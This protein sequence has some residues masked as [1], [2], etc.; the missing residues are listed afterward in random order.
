MNR[1]PSNLTISGLGFRVKASPVILG[2]G[3]RGWGAGLRS[4]RSN[5]PGS[6]LRVEGLG[7]RGLECCVWYITYRVLGFRASGLE[8]PGLA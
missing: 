4:G 2:V 6:G 5:T 3:W 7:V 8:F 1:F